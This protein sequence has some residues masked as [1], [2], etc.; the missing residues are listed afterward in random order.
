MFSSL[1][2]FNVILLCSLIA[3]YLYMKKNTK[4]FLFISMVLFIVSSLGLFLSTDTYLDLIYVTVIFIIG[5]I[6]LVFPCFLISKKIKL[7]QYMMIVFYIGAGIIFSGMR[8]HLLIKFPVLY[9]YILMGFGFVYLLFKF[10]DPIRLMIIFAFILIARLSFPYVLNDDY[11]SITKSTRYFYETESKPIILAIKTLKEAGFYKN[12]FY[13]AMTNYEKDQ[14][15]VVIQLR[16]PLSSHQGNID[17][18]F[19]YR[20]IYKDGEI[21][22]TNIPK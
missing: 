5:L 9:F 10:K 11:L 6:L 12:G 16:D 17:D 4:K 21:I 20:L 3:F 18:R 2:P 15:T 1:I 13:Y 7:S 19:V 14:I 22:D 8:Y